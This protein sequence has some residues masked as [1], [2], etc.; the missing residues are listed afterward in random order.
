MVVVVVVGF[1][2]IDV[3]SYPSFPRAWHK[4]KEE[5]GAEHS[6]CSS[7]L[8]SLRPIPS[9]QANNAKSVINFS[10]SSCRELGLKFDGVLLGAERNLMDFCCGG[11][12]KANVLLVLVLLGLERANEWISLSYNFKKRNV[13]CR[14]ESAF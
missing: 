11:G 4:S 9:Q 13:V 10:M 6:M 2:K 8:I 3:G 14:R 12:K 7:H 5:M 1:D